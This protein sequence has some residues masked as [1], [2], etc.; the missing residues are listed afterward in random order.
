MNN[1]ITNVDLAACG[2]KSDRNAHLVY[3]NC[4]SSSELEIFFGDLLS[5]LIPD[6]IS[7]NVEA[8]PAC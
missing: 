8:R 1:S 5:T 6:T 7:N 4:L 3:L 2:M